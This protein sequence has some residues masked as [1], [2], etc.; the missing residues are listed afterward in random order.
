MDIGSTSVGGAMVSGAEK[1]KHQTAGPVCSTIEVS[2]RNEISFNEKIAPERFLKGIKLVLKQTLTD[3]RSRERAKPS[4]ILVFLS[5]PFYA[6]QTRISRLEKPEP[7]TVTPSLV[8]DLLKQEI[9]KIKRDRHELVENKIMQFRLNGYPMVQPYR[10]KASQL[11]VVSYLGI[12]T[13]KILAEF[14]E[15]LQEVFHRRDVEW[16][17]FTFAFFSILNNFLH[18]DQCFLIIDVGGE[19]TEVSLMG[20]GILYGSASF[21]LGRNSVIRQVAKKLNTTLVSAAD[22]VKLLADGAYHERAKE[23]LLLALTEIKTEWL[24]FLKTTVDQVMTD[25]LMTGGAFMVG[26]P[27]FLPLFRQWVGEVEVETVVAGRQPLKTEVVTE[28][29]LN[30]FCRRSGAVA[31]DPSLMVE[32]IFYDT[33]LRSDNSSL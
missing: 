3:L 13:T 9:E 18:Q 22:S 5:A 17:S 19:I 29:L 26:D 15:V 24:S 32:T 31:P 28:D 1:Q 11:E 33:M 25:C 14:R 21:P 30:H 8:G 7:F 12:A 6:A 27:S 4:R 23:K 2:A 20:R 16:H 10:Q